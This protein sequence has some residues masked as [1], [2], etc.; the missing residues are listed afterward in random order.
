M[1]EVGKYTPEEVWK[2][3]RGVRDPCDKCRGSGEVMYG[4]TSTWHHGIGGAAITRDVCD[5]CWGSGDKSK[6]WRDLR[7]WQDRDTEMSREQAFKYLQ[8][9]FGT[10]YKTIRPSLLRFAD[11]IEKETRRRKLPEGVDEYDYKSSAEIF[12]RAIRRL[13]GEKVEEW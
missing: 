5:T 1:T 10:S 8:L 11:I 6:I 2:L 3:F 9:A 13:C 7:A 12:S 4:N